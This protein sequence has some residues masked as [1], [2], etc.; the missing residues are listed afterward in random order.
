MHFSRVRV[1]T[2]TV[3]FE[4]SV[5]RR[6]AGD[7]YSD[8]IY[9]SVHVDDCLIACKSPTDMSAFKQDLLSRF[10]GTDEGEV[11]EYLGCEIIR[12]RE[13]SKTSYRSVSGLTGTGFSR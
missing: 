13:A 10:V 9:V 11:T 1:L 5:W 2:I 3:G 8:D 6:P 12:D 4:E 7:K